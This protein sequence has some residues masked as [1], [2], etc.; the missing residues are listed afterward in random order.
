LRKPETFPNKPAD[1]V[2]PDRH[3]GFFGHGYAQAPWKHAV[4]PSAHKQ[5]KI[6][7]KKTTTMFITAY[8]V[9]PFFE[10]VLR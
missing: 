2:A 8:K 1:S 10:S 9:R 6:I 3:P 5:D 4:A 7:R